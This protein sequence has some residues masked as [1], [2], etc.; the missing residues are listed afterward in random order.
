MGMD[1]AEMRL[2]TVPQFA[3]RVSRS[4]DEVLALIAN[5]DVKALRPDPEGGYR[6]LETEVD[7]L[8][9]ERTT[10]IKRPAPTQA[11]G[12]PRTSPLEPPTLTKVPGKSQPVEPTPARTVAMETHLAV[13]TALEATR[14]E[15][16]RLERLNSSLQ[17]EL[18]TYRRLSEDDRGQ[19]QEL[20]ARLESAHQGLCAAKLEKIE[21]ERER[22]E[23]E[24]ACAKRLQAELE[25]AQREEAEKAAVKPSFWRRWFG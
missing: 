8:L 18:F 23:L 14:A 25:A 21:I 4:V 5:R 17:A 1:T 3:R 13:V 12:A 10:R 6:V 24:Q 7:R 16:A 20:R 19:L 22:M 2:L 11:E 15:N 9:Q